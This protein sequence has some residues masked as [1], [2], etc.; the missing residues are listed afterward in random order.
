MHH[1]IY[2]PIFQPQSFLSDVG[3]V[4]GLWLGMS[5]LTLFEYVEFLVDMA[6]FGWISRF[7]RNRVKSLRNLKPD[8][9]LSSP[10][11]GRKADDPQSDSKDKGD[12]SDP[13]AGDRSLSQ[14]SLRSLSPSEK[15]SGSHLNDTPGPAEDAMPPLTPG[16][17]GSRSNPDHLMG[18]SAANS[19]PPTGFGRNN[20]RSSLPYYAGVKPLTHGRESFPAPLSARQVALYDPT[21]DLDGASP[22]PP[23][24]S[25]RSSE[26]S[27]D[28]SQNQRMA[29]QTPSEGDSGIGEQ[30]PPG[31]TEN[32][33]PGMDESTYG[34]GAY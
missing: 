30:E 33:A 25:R 22:P 15:E 6:V 31:A 5:I 27:N 8:A 26:V 12:G 14:A 13:R 34:M 10:K 24:S 1:H 11:S 32:N 16:R 7:G 21:M 28:S 17:P 29:W 19:R 3:G 9:Y 20:R 2:T 23:Y 18:S 4:L